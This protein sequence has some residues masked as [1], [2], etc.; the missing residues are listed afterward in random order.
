MNDA[1]SII[2]PSFLPC[3]ISFNI[4]GGN[5]RIRRLIPIPLLDVTYSQFFKQIRK[6]GDDKWRVS[7]IVLITGFPSIFHVFRDSPFPSLD[8]YRNRHFRATFAETS[9]YCH[10]HS[11]SII[12]RIHGYTALV[13]NLILI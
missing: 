12:I 11:S 7:T 1:D 13:T 9:I 5:S 2:F 6:K 8:S 4:V 10:C 3:R